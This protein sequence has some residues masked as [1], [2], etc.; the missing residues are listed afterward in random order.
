MKAYTKPKGKV[1]VTL[2]QLWDIAKAG[3]PDRE[4]LVYCNSMAEDEFFSQHNEGIFVLLDAIPTW[5]QL[6]ADPIT[7]NRRKLL[8]FF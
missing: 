5:E 2:R 4:G 6:K 3:K 8:R 7:Y 1:K